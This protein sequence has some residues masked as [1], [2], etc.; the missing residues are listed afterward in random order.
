VTRTWINVLARQADSEGSKK[1]A[2]EKRGTRSKW[3][4]LKNALETS[5]S[6]NGKGKDDGY[7][8]GKS[9]IGQAKSGRS[10]RTVKMTIAKIGTEALSKRS[11]EYEPIY[12]PLF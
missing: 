9:A 8:E 5:I 7:G 3:A 6:G 10:A 2:S 4:R 12:N 1:E 11:R